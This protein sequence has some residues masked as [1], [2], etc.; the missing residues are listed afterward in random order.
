LAESLRTRLNLPSTVLETASQLCIQAFLRPYEPPRVAKM[1]PSSPI[2]P[3]D[4]A[5]KSKIVCMPETN[6][7]AEL[8]A[9]IAA[10]L[11]LHKS[12]LPANIIAMASK[13]AANAL[14]TPKA[15]A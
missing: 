7:D 13:A 10:S 11:K 12:D 5:S 2:M 4:P 6:P 8:V 15:N 9:Q 3:L 14:T 1:A